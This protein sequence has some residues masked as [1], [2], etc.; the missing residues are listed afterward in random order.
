[1]W[2]LLQ[3]TCSANVDREKNQSHNYAEVAFLTHF[4]C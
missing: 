2:E 1:M 3:G 4:Q